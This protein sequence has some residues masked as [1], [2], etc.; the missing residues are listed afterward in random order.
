MVWCEKMAQQYIPTPACLFPMDCPSSVHQALTLSIKRS[1]YKE[2][3]LAFQFGADFRWK[4]LLECKTETLS[5][6]VFLRPIEKFRDE[7]RPVLGLTRVIVSQGLLL[8]KS[9]L[10]LL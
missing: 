9:P 8:S 1:P 10:P 3:T 4:G 5:L 2:S 6:R 7:K